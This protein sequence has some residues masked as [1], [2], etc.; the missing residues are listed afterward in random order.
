MEK[1]PAASGVAVA[2]TDREYAIVIER[3]D[4]NWSAYAP[5]VPGCVATGDTVEETIATMQEAL[6]LHLDLSAEYGEAPPEA[7]TVVARVRVPLPAPSGGST[8]G[9]P[10]DNAG[11]NPAGEPVFRLDDGTWVLAA[12]LMYEMKIGPLPEGMHV[13]M[14]CGNPACVNPDHFRLVKNTPRWERQHTQWYL[15]PA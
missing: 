3:G 15:R 2:P 8:S 13:A 6:R 12:H 1:H 14:T 9:P 5:D 7:L 10:E 11:F 4:G